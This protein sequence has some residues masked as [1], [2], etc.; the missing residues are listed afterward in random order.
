LLSIAENPNP[1]DILKMRSLLAERAANW[2]D[3]AA[4]SIQVEV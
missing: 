1:V 2:G 3:K 4:R